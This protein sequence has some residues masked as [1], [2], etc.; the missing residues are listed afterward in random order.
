MSNAPYKPVL[1]RY[2]VAVFKSQ[3]EA[4]AFAA[5]DFRNF[6]KATLKEHNS[7]SVALSGG[8]TPKLIFEKIAQLDLV[9]PLQWSKIHVFFG[10]ERVVPPDHPESNYHMAYESLLSKVAV[11]EENIHRMI[12][13]GDLEKGALQYEK[14]LKAYAPN[15]LDFV[16]LGMGEDGHTA[17]LFPN[18]KALDEKTH[19]VKVNWVDSKQCF[20][21]TLTYPAILQARRV[22]VY[23]L[24]SSKSKMI[25]KIFTNRARES[26]YPIERVGTPHKPLYWILDES[27]IQEVKAYL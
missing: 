17:S 8:T 20:R 25:E 26:P 10:D 9:D 14:E 3:E 11:P 6:V 23:A 22:C 24:G 4:V 27:A 13:E 16:M 12:T 2:L 1:D 19:L 18:T 7:F 21:I 15:G 5:E